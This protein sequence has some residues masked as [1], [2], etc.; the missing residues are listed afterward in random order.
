MP[1]RPP[2]P[3]APIGRHIDARRQELGLKISELAKI[4]GVSVEQLRAIRYGLN[5]PRAITRGALDRALRWEPGSVDRVIDEDGDPVS[6]PGAPQSAPAEAGGR[7]AALSALRVIYTGDQEG[8]EAAI[9]AAVRRSYP[10]DAVAAAIMQQ[11]HKP[12]AV[13][14]AELRDWIQKDAAAQA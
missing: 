11:E 2:A 12:L 5:N 8:D 14:W 4:S 3:L 6:L 1:E 9:V 7:A 10:G 13:R